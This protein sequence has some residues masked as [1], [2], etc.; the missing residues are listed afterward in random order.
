MFR[1][2]D[3]E[4]PRALISRQSLSLAGQ[5]SKDRKGRPNSN[6]RF[7]NLLPVVVVFVL[8]R[9]SLILAVAAALLVPE[10][11]VD[12]EM[13]QD[14]ITANDL[15]PTECDS[16]N[17]VN[18]VQGSGIINGTSSN[19]LILGSGSP[20]TIDGGNG[21]DCILGGGQ[22]DVL[23]GGVGYGSG[24]V[25]DKFNA[26]SYSNNDGT[27]LWSGDWAEV[28]ESDGAARGDVKVEVS[29]G[30]GVYTAFTDQ[31]SWL[32]ENNPD[33]NMGTD[34]EL[35]V[36]PTLGEQKRALYRFDLSVVPAGSDVIAAT[37]Y[38]WVTQRN[39]IPVD[40]HRVTDAWTE[41]GVT[42][43]NTAVD[44]DALA[45]GMFTPGTVDQYVA[46]DVTTLVQEWVDG[47]APNE[48]LMLIA[49]AGAAET[50]YNSR[51]EA[52]VL[53]DPFLEIDLSSGGGVNK[54]TTDQESWVEEGSPDNNNGTYA[55]PITNLK[56]GDEKRTI[57]RF[58]LSTIPAGSSVST[59]T[60]H[61]WVTQ[62]NGNPVDVH[63]VTDVWTE[64]G[65]TW[66]N[67]ASDYDVPADGTFTPATV[68]EYVVVDVTA[69]IQEWVD[70]TAPNYGLMLIGTANEQESKYTSR[71]WAGTAE[72]PYMD[73]FLAQGSSAQALRIQNGDKAAWR[74]ADL[75]GAS[76][77][78]LQFEYRREGL[79]DA[80]DYVAVEISDS[81][82]GAWVELARFQGPA[83]DVGLTTAFYDISGYIDNS[84]AV[85]FIS[86]TTLG[87]QDRIYF[88]NVQISFVGSGGD[89]ILLGG[90]GDDSLNGGSGSDVC[91]GGLGNDVYD[92]SCEVQN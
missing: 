9:L 60:A 92:S 58:D 10:S 68:D 34:A 44:Y 61:F 79:D 39:D 37:A 67:T 71:E 5:K 12:D 31:D 51:E 17:L 30:R 23:H 24:T 38:F 70:G 42:W 14:P 72:D 6:I 4:I 33:D 53:K 75:D 21:D 85:R 74:Q 52:G 56:A 63:R 50:K 59:A 26:V 66:N 65:V 84:T 32:K 20:D 80:G 82:G 29:E 7:L 76:A 46:V 89:D 45:D 13:V 73:I 43:N 64:L 15:K 86:S 88:D 48:G 40:V 1:H 19:D 49:R 81:G 36:E 55:E 57:Y 35:I 25:G 69:L 3:H 16:L 90:D 54:V 77:A 8:V 62:A 78:E 28:G 18:I 27:A 47:T 22:G 91:T 41:L 11:G 87:R 2:S 83:T